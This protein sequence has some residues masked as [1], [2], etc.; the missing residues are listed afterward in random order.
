M[1]RLQMLQA[2]AAHICAV[3]EEHPQSTTVAV[4]VQGIWRFYSQV[5]WIP[6]LTLKRRLSENVRIFIKVSM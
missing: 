4:V 6:L 3:A 5:R 2:F 1:A